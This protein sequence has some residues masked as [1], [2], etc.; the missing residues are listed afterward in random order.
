M[1]GERDAVRGKE[2]EGTG[3]VAVHM[4]GE[5]VRETGSG[6]ALVKVIARW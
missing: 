5:A 4:T 3:S 1:N 6:D 2:E